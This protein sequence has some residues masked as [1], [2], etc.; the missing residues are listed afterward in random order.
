M[1]TKH[2]YLHAGY[3]YSVFFKSLS[4]HVECLKGHKQRAKFD[5]YYLLKSGRVM[6]VSTGVLIR[7]HIKCETGRTT[8]NTSSPIR[9]EAGKD[10]TAS[11]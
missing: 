7:K 10:T 8:A 5:I 1:D 11:M 6:S 9:K 3:Y 4:K 2:C